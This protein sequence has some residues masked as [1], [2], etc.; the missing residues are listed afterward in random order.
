MDEVQYRLVDARSQVREALANLETEQS[1]TLRSRYPKGQTALPA[2]IWFEYSNTG[3][4]CPVVDR[5][6]F[7]VELW[8]EHLDSQNDL[9]QAVNRAMLELGLRRV[10]SGP[11]SYD[12]SGNCCRKIFRFG[13]KVDKRSMRLID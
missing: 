5:L 2:V 4:D 8:T 6:V 13:R 7:Q 11:D 3:T 1:Y 12:E 10:Y 9:A